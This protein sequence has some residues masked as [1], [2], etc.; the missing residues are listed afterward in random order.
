MA[1]EPSDNTRSDDELDY[2]CP[3][4]GRS[5]ATKATCSRDGS[6]YA[7][8][9]RMGVLGHRIGNYTVVSKL[10]A[11]GMGEVYR[12]IQPQIGARVAIKVLRGAAGDPRALVEAQA[13]NRGPSGP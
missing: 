5:A 9:A 1:D 10:G 11:G 12:A 3:A 4:C 7:A 2:F 6:A 13:G 8:N